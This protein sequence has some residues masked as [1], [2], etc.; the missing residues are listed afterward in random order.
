MS[1][2]VGLCASCRHARRLRSSRGS[3]FWL[4]QLSATDARFRKYPEL[5][6][7]TCNG[8]RPTRAPSPMD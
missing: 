8:Y 6:V 2:R 3:Q 1:A 4:C 5:P 7:L